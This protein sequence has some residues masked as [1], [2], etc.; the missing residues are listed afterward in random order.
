MYEYKAEVIRVVDGD[1][2]DVMVDLGFKTYRAERLRLARVDAP[3]IRGKEKEKGLKVKEF[4]ENILKDYPFVIVRTE[5][6][7]KYGRYIAEVYIPEM[8]GDGTYSLKRSLS[9]LLLETGRAKLY[10]G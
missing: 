5:K 2:I 10:Q 4:V 7:G 9:N 6:T 8:K 3:E 1:T